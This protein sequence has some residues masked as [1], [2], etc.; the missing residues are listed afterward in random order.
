MRIRWKPK[1][2]FLSCLLLKSSGDTEACSDMYFEKWM[3]LPIMILSTNA[4]YAIHIE[5]FM[6]YIHTYFC[7]CVEFQNTFVH[8]RHRGKGRI[9]KLKFD[10]ETIVLLSTWSSGRQMSKTKQQTLANIYKNINKFIPL[11]LQEG[12][13]TW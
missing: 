7:Y 13:R 2:S 1:K 5:S 9:F 12:R 11:H 6:Y 4:Q 8:L 10:W 3:F